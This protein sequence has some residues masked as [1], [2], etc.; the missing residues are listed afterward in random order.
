MYIYTHTH[1]YNY[2]SQLELHPQVVYSRG[3]Q[4]D[5]GDTPHGGFLKLQFFK[6]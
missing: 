5:A 1:L 2:I 6:L 4:Q 3:F